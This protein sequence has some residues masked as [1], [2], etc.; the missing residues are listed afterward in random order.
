MEV[1]ELIRGQTAETLTSRPTRGA[2]GTG[3][4]L[5]V[6]LTVAVVSGC[7]PATP[8]T[9]EQPIAFS[10]ASHAA[11][12]ISCTR[13]HRG[14]EEAKQADLPALRLCAQCHRRQSPEHPEV[15]KVL[16][17]YQEKTPIPWVKVNHIPERS[18]VQFNHRAHARAEVGCEEC[19]GDVASMGVAEAVRN[20]ADMGWC[21][22][23]HRER[24][25]SD[26]CLTCHY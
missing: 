7:R 22:D 9:P 8:P 15:A 18:M 20:V 11:A 12:E 5:G 14:A 10:H 6:L 24:E 4:L 19:H 16:T 26:D 1:R 23:C 3:L 21:L 13:C 2:C 17:A 25:A